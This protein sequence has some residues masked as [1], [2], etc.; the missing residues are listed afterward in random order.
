MPFHACEKTAKGIPLAVRFPAKHIPDTRTK[1]LLLIV[2]GKYGTEWASYQHQAFLEHLLEDYNIYAT[3]PASAVSDIKFKKANII[4]IIGADTIHRT[5]DRTGTI[6]E[7]ISFAKTGGIVIFGGVP[8]GFGLES[9]EDEEVFHLFG[10]S[11]TVGASTYTWNKRIANHP[12]M[13]TLRA[14]IPATY[15]KNVAEGACYRVCN[16]ALGARPAKEAQC[17]VAYEPYGEGFM[18]YIGHDDVFGEEAWDVLIAMCGAEEA[19]D[20]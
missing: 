10:L 7:I 19:A 12:T 14:K 6:A 1:I 16:K 15:L 8:W 4:L 11:W 13:P 2:D 18:C 17:S 9:D 3:T 20:P 5:C